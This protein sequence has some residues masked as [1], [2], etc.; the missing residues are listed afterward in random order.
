MNTVDKIEIVH[1]NI[2][3]IVRKHDVEMIVNA[4]KRT[5]MG[6]NGVDGAIHKAIDDLNNKTGFFKEMI[7]AELDGT[8]PKKDDINRCDYGKA[9]V[10]KGYKLAN[11]VVHA[12]GPK[13][14]GN[15]KKVGD[16]CSK[17]CIDKLKRCYESVLDCMLE[18]GC[19][20]IAVPVISSGS[21]RFP[22][23][24]AAK[25]QFISICNFL[26]QLRKKDPER[27]E[28]IDK[29]YIVV[30]NQD[31]IKCIEN[32]RNEYVGSVNK[33]K[34]LLYL[35]TEESYKAY[36]KD[37]KDYDSERRNYFGAIKFLRLLLI[38]SEKFFYCTYLLKKC[39][40]DKTWEGRRIFI[41]MQ[42]IIKSIIPFVLLLV[43][44]PDIPIWIRN[45]LTG[46]SVY[47]M[48]ETLIYAA[49]LLFLSDI[50]NPSANSIRS[51]FFLF[52]N[53]LEINFTFAFLYRLYGCFPQKGWL[54]C[55]YEAFEH[56]S[57]VP[58]S[59]LGMILVILQNCI[60]LYLVGIVFTFF[61]NSFRTRKF[62]SI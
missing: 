24:K 13:W 49:K 11:Y 50:L 22:F 56:S 1:G 2:V 18:Y 25:I 61:V 59:Q 43:I 29:I 26:T 8:I 5:L 4:A 19:N 27:F 35:S 14:D 46:V 21:Y 48:S 44:S 47:L 15:D 42:T 38:I 33:G 6:G 30:F 55:L 62:N 39:F 57:Q 45:I 60:T 58:E 31:D 28:M 10:T 16:S 53:Y 17:S 20:T 7:K 54:E 37:I 23:G 36:L 51:I 52:I 12:V 34:Q 3:D 41:E 40:A 9:V 32:I